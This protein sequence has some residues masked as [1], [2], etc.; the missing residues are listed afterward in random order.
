MAETDRPVAVPD[1]SVDSGRSWWLLPN[2]HDGLG[3]RFLSFDED[4]SVVEMLRVDEALSADPAFAAAVRRQV[5]EQAALNSP[6]VAGVTLADAALPGRLELL[7]EHCS[8]RLEE[9]QIP[10]SATALAVLEQLLHATAVLHAAQP[11]LAHGVITG[12]RAALTTDGRVRLLEPVFGTAIAGLSDAER[13]NR[14]LVPRG[15]P[16]APIDQATDVMHCALVGA[17]LLQGHPVAWPDAAGAVAKAACSPEVTAWFARALRTEGDAWPNAGAA[18][19]ELQLLLPDTQQRRAALVAALQPGAGEAA[20][21]KP[22]RTPVR[23]EPAPRPVAAAAEKPEKTQKPEKV[24]ELHE[25]VPAVPAAAP[26]PPAASTRP[27][28]P[29]ATRA[30][31]LLAAVAVLL[32]VVVAAQAVYILRNTATTTIEVTAPPSPVTITAPPVPDATAQTPAV[33][34]ASNTT[35]LPAGPAPRAAEPRPA[36]PGGPVGGWLMVRSPIEVDI[37]RDG[38]LIG[39]SRSARL[40]LPEGRH[41]LEL[42]NRPLGFQQSVAVTI[43]PGR[44]SALPVAVPDG[45]V[46]V[47]AV[48]WAEVFIDGRRVGETPIGNLRL[49]IGSH[50][51]LFRHPTLGERRQ[52]LVVTAGTP[53]RISVE[54]RP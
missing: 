32:A 29:R 11:G 35:A 53:S 26:A 37:L 44:E 34:Q 12:T 31:I 39:T 48:P 4:G 6:W 36:A 27:A 2:L 33:S 14:N 3:D 19:V 49:P 54:L 16:P 41:T 9:L 17:S 13:A 51:V 8:R 10:D 45:V 52:S 38:E 30:Q 50:E 47:N 1:T 40:M 21:P 7:S 28:R 42:V 22:A 46:H 43:A 15:A 5:E 18:L 20:E 24:V 25:K 23:R